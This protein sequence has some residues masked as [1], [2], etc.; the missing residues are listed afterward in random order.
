MIKIKRGLDLPI[1]GQPKLDIEEGRPVRQVALLGS[2]YVGMKPTMYVQEGDR[3]RLGQLLFDDKK[4]EG[5]RYTA[6]AAGT[7]SAI[8]RG[9]K[10]VLQ[11]VVIDVDP[12]AESAGEAETFDAVTPEKVAGADIEAIQSILLESGLWTTLRTRPFS[13]VPEPGSRPG[14]IFVTAMDTQPL[15]ADPTVIIG[16]RR[17]AFS[18]GLDVLARLTDG[19]VF[20][21]TAP[22]AQ[23]P[24]GSDTRIRQETFAGPHP[25]GLA[26]TH[27]HF[28][29]PVGPERTVWTIGYQDVIAI[30]AS[31]IEGRLATERVVSLA[32]RC[33]CRRTA[34]RGDRWRRAAGDLRLRA[35]RARRARRAGLPRALPRSGLGHRRG[36]GARDAALSAAR[37]R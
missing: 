13:R 17:E 20:V 1:S 15:A 30:G 36:P 18:H 14:S 27:I 3:V 7:V 4:N 32:A 31:L 2:D 33:L 22:D 25:A 37:S 23:V 34:G 5:V 19:P 21:C 8:H 11:S 35:F 12:D 6:P 10:R 24:T 16:E 9:A 29:D 26:G 28:L